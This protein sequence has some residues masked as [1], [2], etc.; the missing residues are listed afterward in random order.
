[1]FCY[2]SHLDCLST[3][4]DT[5][6]PSLKMNLTMPPKKKSPRVTSLPTRQ[7]ARTLGQQAPIPN[8]T[9]NKSD[10]KNNLLPVSDMK[11]NIKEADLLIPP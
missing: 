8:L 7:L 3:K 9:E 10:A 2:T 6:T 5:I 11:E 4:I 1:M